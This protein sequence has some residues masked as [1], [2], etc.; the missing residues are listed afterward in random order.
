M[1]ECMSEREREK[2]SDGRGKARERH[3]THFEYLYQAQRIL[4]LLPQSRRDLP[5]LERVV[6]LDFT[7]YAF[8]IHDWQDGILLGVYGPNRRRRRR[9]RK[10]DRE[11]AKFDRKRSNYATKWKA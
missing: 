5:G 9:R 6:F 8:H 4:T 11:E 3:Q 7:P 2:E 1:L 10:K